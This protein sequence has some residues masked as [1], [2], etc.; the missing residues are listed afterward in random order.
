MNQLE[1]PQY[2]EGEYLSAEDL[3]AI[4][5]YARL[6]HAR[7]GLGAHVWG[8]AAGLTLA[9]RTLA[10]GDDVEMVLTPGV[11]WDGYARPLLALAPQRIPLDLF[12]NFQ[13]VTPATGVP[14]EVWLAY[15]ELPAKPP[16]PG[17]AC[18][19]DELFGRA[20]ETFTI[21]L[22][23]TPLT[24]YHAV[25]IASRSIDARQALK[26]FDATKPILFDESV[27]AQTFPESGDRQRWPLFIGVVRWRKDVGQPG[28]LIK[29]T[30]EDKNVTRKGRRYLGAVAETIFAA[31]GVLRLRD[32]TRD[33]AE[34]V[35]NYTPPIV[36]APAGTTI[37]NDLVWCEGH[38]RVVGDTRLQ[39]GK[40]DYRVDRGGDAGVPIYLQRVTTNAPTMKTTLDAFIG[41]PAPP[42]APVDAQ[43]RFT[44]STKDATGNPKECLTVVTDGRVG[45]NAAD[46]TNTLHVN[47]PTGIRYGYGYVT[48]DAGAAWS[49]LAFN[50]YSRPGGPW[51]IPDPAHKPAALVLDDAGGAPELKFQT[52]PTGNPAAWNVHITAKG[53]TGNVGIGTTSPGSRLHV[54]G[55]NHLNS[56]F[57]LTDA[58]EHLTVVVGTVGSGLRFSQTNEFFIASQPYANRNDNTFGSEHLRIKANG[59]TGIG[60]ST[61]GARLHVAGNGDQWGTAA[62]VPAPVK[63]INISH[64]HWDPTGDWYIR[65]ASG[66]GKVVI[67]DS[68]GNVGVGTA[69]PA[70][71]LTV[72]GDRIR[73]GDDNKRIE[74]RTDGSAVDLHSETHDL[75]IR[76]LADAAHP[77][78]RNVL[79]NPDAQEGNVGIGTTNPQ[80]K[81]DVD[82]DMELNGDAFIS[83]GVWL[84][85]DARKKQNIA[86]IERPLERLRA[87]KGVRFDW[88]DPGKQASGAPG[89]LGLVAQDVEAILPQAVSET[90]RGVKAINIGAMQAVVVEAVRELADRCD[91]LEGEV[92]VLRARLDAIGG[93]PVAPPAQPVPPAEPAPPVQPESPA[94]ISPQP[95]PKKPAKKAKTKRARA[96]RRGTDLPPE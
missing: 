76:T 33:P 23:Y 75:W 13:D 28:R 53:D 20:V 43:T 91:R 40:L 73:L 95:A 94:Q 3:N 88:R 89:Q 56:V 12:A 64:V 9:E 84:V 46:P 5:R 65:S 58:P 35:V 44:V 21:E 34:A 39:S 68:G 92:A 11:G 4:V 38:L 62:L 31:D 67:Q 36:A 32:R 1:R 74:L 50:A 54:A 87:L 60:T 90:P 83:A 52:S 66:A 30:D 49:G 37:V 81:L 17:F 22:R 18:P 63:G 86:A 10:G 47:G 71:K 42:P 27:A 69:A 45:I 6:A 59:N 72:V 2:Y 51:V 78:R 24:D 85:S 15:R 7:H 93:G 80:S 55:T 29:R 57:D 70:R 26:E 8:L 25:T 61:P 16:G 19:D 82:G 48:G 96:P 14:I 41:P 79:I 77:G